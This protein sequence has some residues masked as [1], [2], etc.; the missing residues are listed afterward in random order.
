MA[1]SVGFLRRNWLVVSA[2]LA[3]AAAVLLMMTGPSVSAD[4]MPIAERPIDIGPGIDPCG[5]ADAPITPCDVVVNKELFIT[6]LCVVEDP[7]RTKWTAGGADPSAL[8]AWT[9]GKL[10]SGIAG[11]PDVD[12]DPDAVSDFVHHWLEHWLVAQPPTGG[13]CAAPKRDAIQSFLIDPWQEISG[14]GQPLNMKLAPFRLLAIVNRIDLRKNTAYGTGNAGEARFVF[15]VLNIDT[16]DPNPDNWDRT[17]FTVILE[18]N[19]PALTCEAV[20]NWANRWHALGTIPFGPTF[21]KELQKITDDFA[22][23][24]VAPERPNG[25]SISQVRT[26]EIELIT[27]LWELREF[28]LDPANDPSQLEQTPVALTVDLD[29]RNDTDLL[30]EWMAANETDILNEQHTVPLTFGGVCFAANSAINPP[31]TWT[32][33]GFECTETRFKFAFNTCNGCHSTNETNTKFLQVEPRN[34]G[35]ESVLSPF[36]TGTTVDDP[37]CPAPGGIGGVTRV[38]NDLERRALDLCDL[39]SSTCQI[40][41][42]QQPIPAQQTS[43]ESGD[44]RETQQQ[45]QQ[46]PVETNRAI[47]EDAPHGAGGR[48]H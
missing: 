24:N 48:V 12:T 21:N 2:P 36:L 34:I 46:E 23:F 3:L 30:A 40:D 33:P 10:I 16:N 45:Q 47:F 19:Q 1:R 9:F 4:Q 13:D 17:Q 43:Q 44:S 18:Y 20:K 35:D 39:L 31:E 14:E 28:H 6:D 41:I 27:D 8:G 25:S 26:N 7:V 38:F 37:S 5:P 32:A 22:G 42:F 15:G 29:K 11:F